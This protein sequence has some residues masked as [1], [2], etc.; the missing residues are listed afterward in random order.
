MANI[1]TMGYAGKALESVGYDPKMVHDTLGD[2]YSPEAKASLK[3][4]EDAKGFGGTIKAAIQNPLGT[5]HKV[6]ESVPQMIGGAGLARKGLS[7]LP[8]AASAAQRALV[9]GAGEGVMAAGSAAEGIRQQTDD[10]LLTGKQVGAALATGAGTALIGAG[11]GRLAQTAFAR[12][13]GIVDPDAALAGLGGAAG[14]AAIKAPGLVRRA[15]SSAATEGLLEE[16]P[17]SASEQALQNFALDRPIMEGVP[18]AAGLGTV[19]GGVMGGGFGA[20]SKP[21][22]ID[23]V[24]KQHGQDP[25]NKSDFTVDANG[26]VTVDPSRT[27]RGKGPQ[28]ADTSEQDPFAGY[29]AQPD[30]SEPL[31]GVAAPLSGDIPTQ[32]QTPVAQ[33]AANMRMEAQVQRANAKTVLGRA[34]ADATDMQADAVQA[35]DPFNLS[36]MGAT[37]NTDGFTRLGAIAQSL[38]LDPEVIVAAAR[39][40][41]GD[42]PKYSLNGLDDRILAS[43]A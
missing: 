13:L 11:G 24:L 7:M 6:L 19:M 30:T 20:I 12:R 41:V 4:I 1:P 34:A 15:L 18:E 27:P 40:D 37:E 35:S 10:G 42:D 8:A 17:Q 2:L 31:S 9:M 25:Q 21:R 28:P 29:N 16:M 22:V 23:D 5:T 32:P 43:Y 26:N 14:D 38:N 3:N 39:A 33:M 36:G